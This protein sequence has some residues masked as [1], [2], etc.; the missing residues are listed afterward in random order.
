MV[1]YWRR[2]L[3]KW[4]ALIAGLLLV[5]SPYML[6]YGRYVRNESFVGFS[7]VVML[8]AMLRHLEAGGKKYL[9][10]LAGALALHYTAKETAFIY[11]AQALLYLA[12]YFIAQVTRR[13]WKN[14]EKDY[15][16]FIIALGIAVL[17]AGLTVGYGLFIRDTSTLTGTETA[18][19]SDP[20]AMG[21]PLAPPGADSVSP[22]L[23]ILILAVFVALIFASVFLIRGYT[24][25]K[26]RTERTFD[27]LMVTGTI[28]LPM[29]SPFPVKWLESW[30]KVSIPTTAP[31]VQAM[32]TDV[33][34]IFIIV[35]FL[36]LMF[37]IS[38][39]VGLLWNKEKWWQTALVFW[40]PFTVLYTTIFTKGA[41]FFTGAIG[42]LGY[43][44][45]QQDVARGSQ[46]WYFYLLIQIPI[47]EFLPAL[48]LILALILGLR[49]K[50]APKIEQEDEDEVIG[51][52]EESDTEEKNFPNMFSLLVWWSITSIVAFS[53]AG[54]RM[55]WLTYHIAWPMILIT[56]WALGRIIDTTDWAKLKEQHIP[57][58]LAALAI[59][60]V[61]VMGMILALGG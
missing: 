3:G 44:V 13:P 27:L 6:Y 57:L 14:A 37:V 29:L 48:G 16:S 19:P 26:I 9:L 45:V 46:P 23:I 42:S 21:A 11:T 24:W 12:I 4:G 58:T 56:G 18:M 39:V 50:P 41:G 52:L 31:E 20:G 28:V 49:R 7:G 8:Y 30:L 36:V 17:F 40:V 43:W 22:T 53:Y 25:G 5:I 15:R 51:L 2:Y 32:S 60:I 1:W 35:G 47:Y 33:R 10:L 59:F 54:E 34:S 61:G 55:P 38:A